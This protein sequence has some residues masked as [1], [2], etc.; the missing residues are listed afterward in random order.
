MKRKREK[1]SFFFFLQT[2]KPQNCIVVYHLACK[3][4]ESYRQQMLYPQWTLFPFLL[5][6]WLG[7][8]KLS[9]LEV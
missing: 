3:G 1:N 8:T 4:W 5:S 6:S 2:E 7:G 9:R